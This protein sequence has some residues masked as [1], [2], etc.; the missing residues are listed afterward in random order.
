MESTSARVRAVVFSLAI[1]LLLALVLYQGLLMQPE[2]R[3]AGDSGPLSI[4][5]TIAGRAFAST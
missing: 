2:I 1:H 4:S 3:D 5:G